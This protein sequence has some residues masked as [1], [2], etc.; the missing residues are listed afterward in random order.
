V[1]AQR[2]SNISERITIR[3]ESVTAAKREKQPATPT[4]GQA[5]IHFHRALQLGSGI[6]CCAYTAEPCGSGVTFSCRRRSFKEGRN[7]AQLFTKF[8]FGGQR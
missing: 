8:A 7:L 5:E 2:P 3:R 6:H 4:V 1:L